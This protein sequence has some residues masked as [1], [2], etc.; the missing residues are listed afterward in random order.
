LNTYLTFGV[1]FLATLLSLLLGPITIRLA[2]RLGLVDDPNS[3]PHK[4][5]ANRI[6]LVGGIILLVTVVAISLLTGNLRAASIPAIL[7]SA[8]IIFGFGVWD[9]Y[10]IISP[11]WKITGQLIATIFLI[12][13]GVQVR[14]FQQNWLNLVITVFWMIGVTNAYNFVDSMDGLAI[15]LASLAA[16]FFLLITLE[17]QQPNLSLFSTIVLGASLG[18]FYY[19]APPAKIFLG[20]AGAQLLGFILGALAI[21]YNP[22]GFSRVASWYIP[23]LL[24]GVPIF[25]T[26][27]VVLSRLRRRKPIYQAGQDHTYH[28]LVRLG[29]SS[30]RS[31]LTMHMA[32]LLM[33]ALAF[34]ALDLDPVIGNAIFAV[35]LVI[36]AGCLIYLETQPKALSQ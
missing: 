25:D 1:I 3:A 21:L 22:L 2:P 13:L 34:I 33:G 23:I 14:L 31:V 28:R 30:N 12:Y 6:P 36:A 18:V 27:L 17:S 15:G 4:I 8:L 19:N 20:D 24:M 5:H 16:A 11:I 26:T 29:M 35:T 10:K 7:I 32:A 9:D